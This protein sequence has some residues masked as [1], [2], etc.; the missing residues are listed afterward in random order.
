LT[1][2]VVDH[3]GSFLAPF[4]ITAGICVFGASGTLFVVGRVEPVLW[5]VVSARTS[6]VAGAEA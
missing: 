3:T 5:K 2:W 6:K 1:G 4:I